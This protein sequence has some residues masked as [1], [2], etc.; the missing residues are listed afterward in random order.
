MLA[1]TQVQI[2]SSKHDRLGCER[3]LSQN[4]RSPE[5]AGPINFDLPQG[6]EVEI[7]FSSLIGDNIKDDVA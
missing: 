5:K 6:T 3:S 7:M 2:N 4:R 1:V